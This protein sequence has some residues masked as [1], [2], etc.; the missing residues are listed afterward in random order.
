MSFRPSLTNAGSGP[1]HRSGLAAR[2][3]QLVCQIVAGAKC[4]A[5]ISTVSAHR[6]CNHWPMTLVYARSNRPP[7][8]LIATRVQHLSSHCELD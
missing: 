6:A 1:L 4:H 7:L 3:L 8:M 2:H 5:S